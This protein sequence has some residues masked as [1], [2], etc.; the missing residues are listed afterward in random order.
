MKIKMIDRI[1]SAIED[2]MYLAAPTLLVAMTATLA[3]FAIYALE[4]LIK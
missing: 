1:I 2:A 3:A 4:E